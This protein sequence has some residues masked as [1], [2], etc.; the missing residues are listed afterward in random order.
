MAIS[1]AYYTKHMGFW[2]LQD[3][4][5][6]GVKINYNKVASISGSNKEI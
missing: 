5:A 6:P 2:I 3:P 1:S 4:H